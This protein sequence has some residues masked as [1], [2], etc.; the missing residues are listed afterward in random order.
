M[1]VRPFY[2]FA[3]APYVLYAVTVIAIQQHFIGVHDSS[4]YLLFALLLAAMCTALGALIA[5]VIYRR[6]ARASHLPT[7]ALDLAIVA[8]VIFLVFLVRSL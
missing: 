6:R 7:L 5:G 3:A 4:A 8:Q 2:L 1:P